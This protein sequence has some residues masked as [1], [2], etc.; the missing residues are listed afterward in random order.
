MIPMIEPTA[1]PIKVFN[2]CA[3]DSKFKKDDTNGDQGAHAGRDPPVTR[4]GSEH[5]TS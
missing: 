4:N 3:T 5:I 2:D 1:A